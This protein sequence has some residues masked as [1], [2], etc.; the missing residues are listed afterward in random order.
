[1]L[2]K[3]GIVG[4]VHAESTL[5]E[6]TLKFMHDLQLQT[7]ICVGDVV[8]GTEN[9]DACCQL[10]QENN[11]VT[12]CGN[13]DRWF[14]ANEA[15]DLAEAT[16]QDN[17]TQNTINF[18]GG[19]PKTREFQTSMGDLLLCH[20]LGANDMARLTPDDY[21]YAI[22][23]NMDLQALIKAQ[24]YRFVINGHTHR[25]MVRSFA[26]LTIIN[27]GTLKH[28]HDPCFAV[29]DF[30]AGYV[31]FHSFDENNSIHTAEEH[32]L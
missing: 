18:I 5:L 23:S 19:F 11:I 4:D 28:D 17:V 16:L 24:Q 9:V 13:R 8:D 22:E 29:A 3:I 25:R 26:R 32:R 27:A 12:V 1:M 15:R 7:V 20:G 31:R 6:L 10:L 14:L 30:T 2:D 21:G